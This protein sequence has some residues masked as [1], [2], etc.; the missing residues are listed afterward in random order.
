MTYSLDSFVKDAQAALR[1]NN[2]AA[3]REQVRALLEKLLTNKGFVDEAVGPAAPIGT[4]KLYEDK[5]LGFVVL[6]HCNPKA[7]KSPP[8]DHG[9]SW[10]VYGQAVS[11]TDMSEFK[12]LDSGDGAGDAK[13]EKVK[14]YRLEPGHAGVYDVGAIHAI[15]YPEGSRF[16][17]V[18]GRDL[19]HVRRL[20][21]D[22][23]AGKAITIE[24]AT[25][26]AAG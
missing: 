24:S 17:R 12:R 6:A 23:A 20:K 22:T 18:T 13:I 25:A 3:G 19:D 8:H 14:T 15:D 7:H 1:T 2:N 21:F 26:G 16:V 4:R 11:Y 5:D 9:S 10:A